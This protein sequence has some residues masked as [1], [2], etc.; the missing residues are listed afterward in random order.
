MPVPVT[1]LDER[2]VEFGFRLRILQSEDLMAA[3]SFQGAEIKK[4]KE[5]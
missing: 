1:H 5:S 3:V 2:A 4:P